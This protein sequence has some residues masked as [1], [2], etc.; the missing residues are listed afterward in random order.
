MT[1]TGT[2]TL[3]SHTPGPWFLEDDPAPAANIGHVGS[4]DQTI[5]TTWTD[6]AQA[7]ARLIAAAPELLAALKD[8]CGADR[9]DLND[10]TSSVWNA[11]ADAIAKATGVNR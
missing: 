11:A 1:S 6:N 10:G 3:A 8:L 9:D 2:K 4:S 5:C 7:N